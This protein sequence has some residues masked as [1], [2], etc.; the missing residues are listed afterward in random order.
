MS[1][2]ARRRRFGA[3]RRRHDARIAVESA[4]LAAKRIVFAH[5]KN[6]RFFERR[7]FNARRSLTTAAS[8]C[9]RSAIR[10]MASRS[11]ADLESCKRDEQHA[12]RSPAASPLLTFDSPGASI[13][14]RPL[15]RSL[16]EQR[17][18]RR[19]LVAEIVGARLLF[20]YQIVRRSPLG[21]RCSSVAGRLRGVGQRQRRRRHEIR[22]VG[23]PIVRRRHR[24][25]GRRCLQVARAAAILG[26]LAR[27]PAAAAIRAVALANS[28]AARAARSCKAPP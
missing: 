5:P 3:Q 25:I 14:L 8:S 27:P 28:A 16:I 7:S 17:Y 13:S 2:R 20:F 11:V 9:S 23:P 26:R 22:L 24:Q 1:L 19:S 10:S 12:D 6:A 18:L 15:I 21:F 4:N